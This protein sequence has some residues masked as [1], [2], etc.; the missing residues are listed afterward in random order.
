MNDAGSI[1]AG[2]SNFGGGDFGSAFLKYLRATYSWYRSAADTIKRNK[3]ASAD[4]NSR[5]ARFVNSAAKSYLEP[6]V[7]A[8]IAEAN[9]YKETLGKLHEKRFGNIKGPLYDPERG[10]NTAYRMR[11]SDLMSAIPPNPFQG[12]HHNLDI[13]KGVPWPYQEEKTVGYLPFKWQFYLDDGSLYGTP[14]VA[15]PILFEMAR[16]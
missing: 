14:M 13:A 6:I 4:E 9:K 2:I 10:W 5:Y 11:Q 15:D 3:S 16:A 8:R 1:S 7:D 12:I